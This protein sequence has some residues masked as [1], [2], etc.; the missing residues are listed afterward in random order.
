M[1]LGYRNSNAAI[2][3]L[4]TKTSNHDSQESSSFSLLS[5]SVIPTQYLQNAAGIAAKYACSDIS[6]F[7]QSS[8]AAVAVRSSLTEAQPV[9][10]ELT[11]REASP[12]Q[13]S[14][15]LPCSSGSASKKNLSDLF[16]SQ[17]FASQPSLFSPTSKLCDEALSQTSQCGSDCNDQTLMQPIFTAESAQG[18]EPIPLIWAPFTGAEYR[19][20]TV[21]EV[22]SESKAKVL[23]LFGKR[24]KTISIGQL[25]TAS[26]GMGDVVLVDGK[27]AVVS[28]VDVSSL[29]AE[30][31]I[32]RS[33]GLFL[34]F[35]DSSEEDLFCT[36][37]SVTAKLSSI[38]L[39]KFL[40]QRRCGVRLFAGMQFL[41]TFSDPASPK[42]EISRVIQENGGFIISENDLPFLEAREGDLSRIL[43]TDAPKRTLKF[44]YAIV[45]GVPR[46]HYSWLADSLEKMKILDPML[47]KKRKFVYHLPNSHSDRFVPRRQKK[48]MSGISVS[49]EGD[50]PFVSLWG[51][52]IE[53]CGGSVVNR[54]STGTKLH[55]S[56]E[57]DAAIETVIDH[58]LRQKSFT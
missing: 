56:R 9:D 31:L 32:R 10:R 48:I 16:A 44:L 13:Q 57:R 39:S 30:L 5:P 26:L 17:K 19:L 54:G 50:L 40:F 35:C 20:A 53:R 12:N 2:A 11:Q 28:D 43:L 4:A 14:S 1:F 55:L 49:I 46:V 18:P 52:L 7:S 24:Q 58:I 47:K 27:V 37:S 6:S 45:S 41:V 22:V 23:F 29:T 25:L 15:P 38:C 34:R 51:G 36:T 3:L 21:S 8:S 42:E 33:A